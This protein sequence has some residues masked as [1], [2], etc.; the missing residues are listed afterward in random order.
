MTRHE[1]NG[2]ERNI[3]KFPIFNQRDSSTSGKKTFVDQ[4]H[5]T[6][7]RLLAPK[8]G[9]CNAESLPKVY[10]ELKNKNRFASFKE[11]IELVEEI[12]V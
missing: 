9:W 8:M 4:F 7:C 12:E 11:G 1:R 10:T 3:N 5:G 6:H 2:Q